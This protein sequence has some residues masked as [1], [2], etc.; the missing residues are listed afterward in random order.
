MVRD[1]R[2]AEKKG[3]MIQR[4]DGI[5]DI[6]VI[7]G[8]CVK[9]AMFPESGFLVSDIDYKMPFPMTLPFNKIN[10]YEVLEV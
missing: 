3:T 4:K 8:S 9:S 7:R 10:E 2:L 1:L 6:L 5:G